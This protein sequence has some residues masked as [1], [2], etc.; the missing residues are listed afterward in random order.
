MNITKQTEKY[1]SEHPSIKGCLKKDLINYSELSRQ[2]CS[3]LKIDKF[4]AVLI[5]CRRYFWKIKGEGGHD[6]SIINLIKESKIVVRN[7]IIVAII[8]KPRDME[9]LYIFQKKVKKEKG[10]L[11]IIQGEETVTIITNQS[12]TNLINE[13]FKSKI[14]KI[15]QNLVQITM[16]FDQRI[17]TT[18]GVVAFVYSL[19][20]DNGI[21]VLEEMSCWTDLMIVIDENDLA[22]SMKVL[23][24]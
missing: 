10:D 9:S 24:S 8:E 17:E 2:I 22:K 21:N 3:E 19:L 1:I 7:K 6:R 11:N 23:G 20:A 4:D 12:F 13:T 16:I 18:S 15:T 5:A 14:I